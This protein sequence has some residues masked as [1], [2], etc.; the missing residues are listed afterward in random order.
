MI[1][2]LAALLIQVAAPV[3]APPAPPP[4]RRMTPV[5][6][7]A[8]LASL[9]SDED[10]PAEAARK[11]EEGTVGFRLQVGPDGMVAVCTI[12]SSSGHLSLD[13]TTC[14]LLTER[15]RFS[16]ARDRRGRPRGDSVVGRITWRLPEP[17]LARLAPTLAI[18]SI[19]VTPEGDATC[20]I[21]L[22]GVPQEGPDCPA[23]MKS[24]MVDAARR[25]DRILEETVVTFVTPNGERE[26]VDGAEH[27]TRMAAVDALLSIA[28]DGSVLECRIAHKEIDPMFGQGD[29]ARDPCAVF[30]RGTRLFEPASGAGAG[31]PRT[32][33][34][35]LRGYYRILIPSNL[36]IT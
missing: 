31:A 29:R 27:G 22:N 34:V 13:S 3:P 33:S 11:R 16:P 14:R 17:D 36:P 21:I 1:S 6:A 15:A 7:K 35:K 9:F 2:A 32:V 28:S 26:M 23:E 19:R 12:T 24:T 30:A 8:N 18:H 25:G 5:R 4:P 20:S 10:Y